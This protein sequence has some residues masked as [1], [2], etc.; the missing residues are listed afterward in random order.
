MRIVERAAA[1]EA[2]KRAGARG[3]HGA[4]AAA[5]SRGG[6]AGSLPVAPTAA[7]A[8]L[9][10]AHP[11][12]GPTDTN[13]AAGPLAAPADADALR[14]SPPPF[15]RAFSAELD[16][17][18]ADQAAATL[19]TMIGHEPSGAPASAPV[20]EP[21][22][23]PAPPLPAPPSPPLRRPPPV[24]PG[25]LLDPY[26]A[27]KFPVEQLRR[28]M[29]AWQQRGLHVG[30][31]SRNPLLRFLEGFEMSTFLPPLE[32]MR[33]VTS[34]TSAGVD[35]ADYESDGG[36]SSRLIPDDPAASS[37]SDDEGGAFDDRW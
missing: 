37:E 32:R 24:P 1:A 31:L 6:S 18:F 15:S 8:L 9:A 16:L 21:A 4:G 34:S 23:A 28:S 17:N 36:T 22:P 27:D 10:S 30:P 12:A 5:R 11:E 7:V 13:G 3:P 20:H 14:P 25:V 2:A 35:D 33:T 19:R 26:S 29:H